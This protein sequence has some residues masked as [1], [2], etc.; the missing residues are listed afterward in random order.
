MSQQ[1]VNLYNLR[2]NQVGF[3]SQNTNPAMQGQTT[4]SDVVQ[5]T[6]AGQLSN[7][8]KAS[9]DADP[10]TTLGLT[11]G[12]GY[13]IGQGMDV[14]NRNF[15]Q[16]YSKTITGKVANRVDKFFENN[17]VGKFI[18]GKLK[19]FDNWTTKKA[20]TSKLMYS[21]KHHAT[22]A[23]WKFAKFFTLGLKGFLGADTEQVIEG[24]IDKPI[25]LD[26]QKLEQYRIPQNE[27]NAFKAGCTG[28]NAEKMLALQI[29]ELEAL[30]QN[31]QSLT[32]KTI[33]ELQTLAKELK[34][35]KVGFNDYA[36]F[37]SLKGK[38]GEKAKEMASILEK[39]DKNIIIT[40]LK[41]SADSL[42]GRAKSHFFGREVGLQELSNKFNI[43]F[44]KNN[45]TYFGRAIPK[46][47]AWL[48]EGCTNRFAGGKFVPLMQATIFADMLYHIWNAPKGEKFQTG[49]ERFVNDFSIFIGGIIGAIGMH[50][51]GGFKYL[52]VDDAGKEAYRQALKLHNENVVNKVFNNKKEFKD[53]LKAVKNLL[54][55]KD[56]NFFQKGLAKLGEFINCGN[57]HS[58]AYRS[59]S[60]INMNWLRRIKNTNIL[61]APMRFILPMFIIGPFIGK[62]ATKAVHAII[63]RPTVSVLDEDKEEEQQQQNPQQPALQQPQQIQKP[64]DT[65]KLSDSNLIKQTVTGQ[66]P[67][68]QNPQ[69]NQTD[70]NGR[71]L[72][73]Q[74]TYIPSPVGMVVQNANPTAA[75]IALNNAN[76]SEKRIQD[77]MGRM[78]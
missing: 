8:L 9:K 5:S 22:E 32:G 64:I 78:K 21:L 49:A 59:K 35:K 56:L 20:Q 57:E 26:F 24:F 12:I 37:T 34:S 40:R 38:F 75:E 6:G 43:L 46:A 58:L 53:S 39:S 45:K 50:K 61:G 68:Q 13:G 10:L 76:M 62:M 15:N 14:Y 28:T 66:Q 74:R 23:Q 51:I 71:T 77:L 60:A 16:E 63:G 52:G 11:L 29:R 4:A 47:M 31:R 41:G 72:E 70:D 18:E 2:N 1:S 7:R 25:G 36:H 65:T 17:S 44:G 42:A 27:I 33:E 67:Q 3:S 69:N 55:R 30:G 19:A 54:N 73:P 48:T